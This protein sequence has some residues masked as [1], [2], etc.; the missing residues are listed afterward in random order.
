MVNELKK[1][2]LEK[3]AHFYSSTLF[4]MRIKQAVKSKGGLEI[5]A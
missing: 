2:P 5:N 3:V 1:G 4:V